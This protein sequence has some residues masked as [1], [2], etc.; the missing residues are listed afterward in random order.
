[1]MLNPGAGPS[2]PVDVWPPVRP[3][4]I[5]FPHPNATL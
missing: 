2:S 4:A 1:M 5:S 3:G